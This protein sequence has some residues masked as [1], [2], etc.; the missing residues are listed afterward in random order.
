[1]S[2]QE[3]VIRGIGF[4]SI[5]YSFFGVLFVH[6]FCTEKVS[7]LDNG[8][9]ISLFI[10]GILQIY[11]FVRELVSRFNELRK[12]VVMDNLSTLK[13]IIES[14][15]FFLKSTAFSLLLLFII[16]ITIL[17]TRMLL[18]TMLSELFVLIILLGLVYLIQQLQ[19]LSKWENIFWLLLPIMYW[20]YLYFFEFQRLC[21]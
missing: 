20:G 16:L 12:T 21:K 15:K 13:K 4:F 1:M 8:D 17:I 5:G 18:G 14:I 9:Y 2:I 3:R 7:V 6:K 11:L 19:Q 10:L